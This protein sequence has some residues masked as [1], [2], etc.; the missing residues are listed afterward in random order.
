MGDL[1][2]R[3][4]SPLFL[5]LASWILFYR[6]WFSIS[7]FSL[8]FNSRK[9]FKNLVLDPDQ[10]CTM[11]EKPLH[12]PG[13]VSHSRS[14]VQCAAVFD[15]CVLGLPLHACITHGRP[16]IHTYHV[17]T[18][19]L[20]IVAPL[21]RCAHSL[22]FWDYDWSGIELAP[23]CVSSMDLESC[24]LPREQWL[25]SWCFGAGIRGFLAGAVRPWLVQ[26]SAVLQSEQWG[27][28]AGGNCPKFKKK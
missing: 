23:V 20:F 15:F 17:C 27:W 14:T 10:S 19:S 8:H 6:L 3:T 9:S 11:P 21:G 1:K 25:H 22:L 5:R 13:V 7:E 2:N 16:K 26:N 4:F 12:A 18:G 28:L 24:V